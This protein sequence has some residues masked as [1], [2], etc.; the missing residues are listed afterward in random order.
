MPN[1]NST[2]ILYETSNEFLSPYLNKHKNVN[3]NINIGAQKE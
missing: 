1:S 2:T 3:H